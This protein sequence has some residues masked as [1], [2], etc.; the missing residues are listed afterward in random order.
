[1]GDR[2]LLPLCLGDEIHVILCKK[3]NQVEWICLT[4]PLKVTTLTHQS[5]SC[6]KALDVINIWQRRIGA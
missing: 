1:M 5:F 6:E 3:I 2:F 4:Y